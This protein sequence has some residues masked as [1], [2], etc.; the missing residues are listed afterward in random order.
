MA[1]THSF[2][3]SLYRHS[4]T[5]YAFRRNPENQEDTPRPDMQRNPTRTVTQAQDGTRK[6]GSNSGGS[7]STVPPEIQQQCKHIHIFTHTL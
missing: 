1:P 5:A 6:S 7:N 2:T 3:H 4:Q